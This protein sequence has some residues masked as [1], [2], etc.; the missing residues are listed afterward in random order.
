[1]T[2]T[3]TSHQHTDADAPTQ[4]QADVLLRPLPEL[5]HLESLLPGR[6][7]QQEQHGAAGQVVQ[8]LP[9]SA[10]SSD[11]G[12]QKLPPPPRENPRR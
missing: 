9:V 11:S 3:M 2:L 7:V 12:E 6:E 1:M 4:G 5:R 8:Q 10:D